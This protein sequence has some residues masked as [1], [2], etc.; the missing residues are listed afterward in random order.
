MLLQRF[1]GA[2]T[3]EHSADLEAVALLSQE[4]GDLL[5]NQLRAIVE[6]DIPIERSG[7]LIGSSAKSNPQ[8]RCRDGICQ[9]SRVAQPNDGLGSGPRL[10]IARA[11]FLQPIH[12]GLVC[13][14]KA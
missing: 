13:K 2:P 11:T 8:P 14:S 4:L 10:P 9:S 12:T 7:K 6:G 5:R 1:L 3:L